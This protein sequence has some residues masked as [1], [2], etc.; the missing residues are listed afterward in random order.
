MMIAKAE[1][2]LFLGTKGMGI[3]AGTKG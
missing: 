3:A 1:G 2:A